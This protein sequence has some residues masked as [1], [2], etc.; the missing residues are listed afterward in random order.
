MLPYGASNFFR[1]VGRLGDAVAWTKHDEVQDMERSVREPR[2]ESV[3]KSN[4]VLAQSSDEHRASFPQHVSD[5]GGDTVASDQQ[6]SAFC[7]ARDFAA[8][9]CEPLL[10]GLICRG[11]TLFVEGSIAC[12]HHFSSSP[13][14]RAEQQ[15]IPR[16]CAS[17]I[18]LTV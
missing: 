15:G 6:H 14:R 10:H 16:C 1:F 13:L 17:K 4:D 7:A 18:A 5:A 12:L 9:L 11:G 8:S 3:K 2:D